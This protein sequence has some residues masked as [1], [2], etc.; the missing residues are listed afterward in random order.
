LTGDR[1]IPLTGDWR[2]PRKVSSAW[3]CR[4]MSISHSPALR[5]P[6]PVRILRCHRR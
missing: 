6:H 2:I 3:A 5:S 1:R 4:F